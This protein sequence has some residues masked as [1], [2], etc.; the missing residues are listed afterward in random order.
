MIVGS[1]SVD[2]TIAAL[3]AV[4]P[5]VRRAAT[6]LLANDGP[7]IRPA[8]IAALPAASPESAGRIGDLLLRTVPWDHVLDAPANEWP[9]N[10]PGNALNN[11]PPT[12]PY[13]ALSVDDRVGR[14]F[15]LPQKQA[16]VPVLLKV[17]TSDPSAGAR[18]AAANVLRAVLGTAG[19]SDGDTQTDA[20]T[21]AAVDATAAEAARAQARA[22]ATQVLALVDAPPGPST[23]PSPADNGPLLAAAAWAAEMVDPGRADGLMTRA[24]AVDGRSPST[25]G[26]PPSVAYEWAIARATSRDDVPAL[27]ALT[28]QYA[29]RTPC[30]ADDL[31]DAIADLFALHADHG[32]LPGF[33]DDVRL[34][35]PYLSQP[36]VLYCLARVA[37]S[38]GG[39]VARLE[40]AALTAAAVVA[41]GTSINDHVAVAEFLVAHDQPDAAAR[42]LRGCLLLAGR[43][44]MSEVYLGMYKLASELDDDDAAARCLERAMRTKPDD[45]TLVRH[46]R[47]G[48]EIPWND[49]DRWAEVHWHKLRSAVTAGDRPAALAEAKQLLDLDAAN[50]VLS[51]DPGMAADIVPVLTD[52][53][54]QTEADQCFAAAY[55]ALSTDATRRPAD[56]MPK[57]NLAWLCARSDRHMN[58]AD[59]LSADAV[60]LAPADAACLDTRAEVILRL[61]RPREAVDLETKALAEKPADIYMRRQLTRFRAAAAAVAAPAGHDSAPR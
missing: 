10:G 61:G 31:P 16:S 32:P 30:G 1:P 55:K 51:N 48:Q 58:E 39:I 18:W 53:G 28:R 6:E 27:L 29:A 9:V 20:V 24:L 41:G 23:Y 35:R 43:D 13:A 52:A 12:T 54:R 15:Q 17:L 59:Q 56:P 40:T 42:E 44:K 2:R 25:D 7:A 3:G 37:A 5:N 38:Q 26:L 19:S 49:P 14:V 57:N 60:R 34:Y 50:Q 4:D 33:A 21:P 36:Q 46:N 22:S 47:F 45:T 8:L 11:N